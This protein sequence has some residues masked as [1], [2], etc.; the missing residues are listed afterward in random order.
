M[1]LIKKF[2]IGLAD[3]ISLKNVCLITSETLSN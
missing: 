1:S 3:A 2:L